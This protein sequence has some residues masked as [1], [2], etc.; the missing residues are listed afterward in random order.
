[1]PKKKDE[2]EVAFNA[3]QELITRDAERDGALISPAPKPQKVTSAV[4]AGRLGGLKG[5]RARAKSLSGKK[6]KAIARKAA[7][8]RW[9]SN[10]KE[11]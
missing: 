11:A 3:L 6:R 1:M 10:K 8:T 7:K 9:K 2:S 4:T 5:G